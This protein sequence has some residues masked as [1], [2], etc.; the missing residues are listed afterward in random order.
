MN[1]ADRSL[2]IGMVLDNRF[3]PDERVEKEALSLIAAGFEVFLLCFSF[4]KS[5]AEENYKGIQIR[6]VFMPQNLYK[7]LSA[8]ILTVPFYRWFW[9]RKIKRF[10]KLE[11]ID[12]LHIHDLPLCGVGLKIRKKYKIPLVADMH[13]NYPVLIEQEKWANTFWG[14]L[15]INK[16][17]WYRV[18]KTWLGEVDH[19]ICVAEEMK[20]RF[21]KIINKPKSYTILPNYIDPEN[22]LAIQRP[23]P[24]IEE[25]FRGKFGVMYYGGFDS[26]RGIETLLEAGK[27]LKDKIANLMIILIGTGSIM[28][29]LHGLAAQLG[30]SDLVAFEGWQNPANLSSY[31]KNTRVSVIPHLKSEQTDNSSPNKLFVFMLE[32]K[33]IVSTNC[34]SLEKIITELECGLI[35]PSAD[36]QELAKNIYTLYQN[37]GFCEKM[38]NSGF[39][40]V[41]EQYN[42]SGSVKNLIKFYQQI[43]LSLD[44]GATV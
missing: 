1:G 27:I 6:R 21:E 15:L 3:P 43:N 31:M 24:E 20:K 38:G 16:K 44:R 26:M 23:V 9:Y 4:G 7:K 39:R 29:K 22:Y 37:P 34:H 2:R 32:K 28:P 17:K 42:W 19:I 41:M 5:A 13:E 35:Y 25:K 18:E 33:P 30:I 40:A 14:R 10:V 36:S 8:L 12:C 11:E